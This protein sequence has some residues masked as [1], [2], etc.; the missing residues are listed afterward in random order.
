MP[1]RRA[2]PVIG[3][4]IVTTWYPHALASD[5]AP[6]MA[7]ARDPMTVVLDRASDASPGLG[8]SSVDRVRRATT[9]EG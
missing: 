8:V 3:S 2:S 6:A 7:S 4:C 1:A 5:A 9:D